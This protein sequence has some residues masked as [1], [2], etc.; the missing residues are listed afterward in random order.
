[1]TDSN[2]PVLPDLAEAEHLAILC[3]VDED[4]EKV[5]LALRRASA[6]FR[7]AVRHPVT[8]VEGDTVELNGDG[9]KSLHLPAAPV[10]GTPTVTVEG[11]PVTDFT[12][13]RNAGILHRRYGWP[14]QLG[15]I[16]VTYDHGY[17]TVPPDIEDAVLEQAHTIYSVLPAVQ[18]M[19]QG[20]RSITFSLNAATGVTQRWAD[21][22]AKYKLNGG[23]AA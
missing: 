4:D 8:L 23:D 9:G 3:G 10:H 22:V 12:I 13:D 18:Q 1:M 21:T 11:E 14:K 6:R 17:K 15:A 5:A 19:S 7:G 2:T 20:G 16:T